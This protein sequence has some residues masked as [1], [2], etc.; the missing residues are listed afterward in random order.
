MLFWLLNTTRINWLKVS[1]DNDCKLNPLATAFLW[2]MSSGRTIFNIWG[3]LI[4]E[5]PAT[6]KPPRAKARIRANP[7]AFNWLNAIFKI[8]VFDTSGSNKILTSWS[9]G[10]DIADKLATN[11]YPSLNKRSIVTVKM[12]LSKD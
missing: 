9:T 10:G 8:N 1:I 5:L 3:T 2:A 6:N 11:I 7:M 12:N 4:H